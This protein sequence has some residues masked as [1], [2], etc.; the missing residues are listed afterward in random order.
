MVNN[1]WILNAMKKTFGKIVKSV[2][3]M[4]NSHNTDLQN[5]TNTVSMV[6]IQQIS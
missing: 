3:G 2:G 1:L 6:R 5:E 4:P